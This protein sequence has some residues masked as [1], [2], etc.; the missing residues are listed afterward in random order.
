[1]THNVDIQYA[2]WT[3]SRGDIVAMLHNM[4]CGTVTVSSIHHPQ[5]QFAAAME[6]ADSK[7]L[8]ADN[9]DCCLTD[10]EM[11]PISDVQASRFR[12]AIRFEFQEASDA[13]LFKLTFGGAA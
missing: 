6:I 7:M 2:V 12:Y 10:N 13:L 8:N 1:M 3:W 4:D 5:T 11:N 9:L